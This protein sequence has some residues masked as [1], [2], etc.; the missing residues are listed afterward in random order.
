[1]VDDSLVK[2][3]VIDDNS[4]IA[5]RK[6]A[7]MWELVGGAKKAPGWPVGPAEWRFDWVNDNLV[8]KENADL[9]LK[10]QALGPVHLG[11]SATAILGPDLG[12]DDIQAQQSTVTQLCG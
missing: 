11:V 1:M 6:G 12:K 10:R 8:G 3:V 9:K 5:N 4:Y 7:K 2:Y